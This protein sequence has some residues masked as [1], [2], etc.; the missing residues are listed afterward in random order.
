M[1]KI[2]ALIGDAA[3]DSDAQCRTLAVGAKACGGPEAYVAWSTKRTD[4]A[5]LH[6]ATSGEGTVAPPARPRP[7]MVSN[8]SIVTD[9][10][11][12]CAPPGPGAG[13]AAPAQS[14]V[15][16]LRASGQSGRGP[17]D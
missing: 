7:G 6:A 14:R 15:C 8:C 3:C 5:A 13:G 11:A 9:P 1:E 17:V 10:G 2:R 16:R 12:Y 4:A